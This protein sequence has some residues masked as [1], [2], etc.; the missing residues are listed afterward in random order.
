MLQL[1]CTVA[2]KLQAK[3]RSPP[4]L[5]AQ[6]LWSDSVHIHTILILTYLLTYLIYG[7]G[8]YLKSLLSLSLSR[9]YSAFFLLNPKVQ[10]HVHKSRPPDPILSQTN[11]I[12]PIDPYLPKVHLNAILPPTPR[13]SKWFLTFGPPNQ[14]P[15]NISPLPH[16]CHMSRPPHPPW[17]NHPNY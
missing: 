3:F 12:C 1:T 4:P 2:S 8:Y 10:Y 15:V 5:P 14:N 13:S 11:P 16:V 17:F 7:A 6:A 9:K